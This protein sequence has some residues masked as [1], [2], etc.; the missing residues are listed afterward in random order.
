VRS[1]GQGR[2]RPNP[3]L[4]PRWM[5]R[6]RCSRSSWRRTRRWRRP[7]PRRSAPTR[8]PPRSRPRPP[9]ACRARTRWAS[10][11]SRGAHTSCRRRRPPTVRAAPR[12][13]REGRMHKWSASARRRSSRRSGHSLHGFEPGPRSWPQAAHRRK[14]DAGCLGPV[15]VRSPCGAGSSASYQAPWCKPIR[16]RRCKWLVCS[17]RRMLGADAED[18]ADGLALYADEWDAHAAWRP[19]AAHAEPIGAAAV[20]PANVRRNLDESKRRCFT[21]SQLCLFTTPPRHGGSQ[22]DTCIIQR[23]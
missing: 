23:G 12:R 14:R 16:L 3:T 9:G 15:A 19:W 21:L 11:S 1:N 8:R 20:M 22:C 2:A 13:A 6:L 10:R 18:E 17:S 4:A 5:G 7:R